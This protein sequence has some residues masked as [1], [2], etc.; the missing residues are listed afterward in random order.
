MK[1]VEEF[2][3]D[4]STWK[5]KNKF[6]KSEKRFDWYEMILFA[7]NYNDYFKRIRY[8]LKK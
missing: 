6:D 1:S 8:G 7:A 5:P 4:Y 2:F 3:K